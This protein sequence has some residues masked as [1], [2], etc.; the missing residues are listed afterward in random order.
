M[1]KNVCILLLLSRMLG[2]WDSGQVDRWYWVFYTL[3]DFKYTHSIAAEKRVLKSL[4]IIM[5]MSISPCTSIHF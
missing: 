4:S 5:D 2:N 3:A 1:F